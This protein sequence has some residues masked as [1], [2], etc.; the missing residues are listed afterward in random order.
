[1]LVFGILILVNFIS[2]RVFS[3]LDLTKAGVYTLSDA[4]KALVRNLDDRVTVKA[5]SRKICPPRT[6]ITG[7]RYSIF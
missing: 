4:S 2:V 6:I 5:Y 3:R 1:M 7:G